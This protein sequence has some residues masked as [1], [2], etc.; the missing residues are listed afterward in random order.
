M[1]AEERA[2]WLLGNCQTMFESAPER[3]IWMGAS[4]QQVMAAL[5]APEIRAA[6]V[7][8][9]SSTLELP[10]GQDAMWFLLGIVVGFALA[11][12]SGQ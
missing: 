8:L 6:A 3:T 12:P 7:Q 5:E 4:R 1:I 11:L 9:S 10:L 2:N